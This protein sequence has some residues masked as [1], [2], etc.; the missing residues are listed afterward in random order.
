MTRASR[1]DRGTGY[2]TIG[3]LC[4]AARKPRL[5]AA[6]PSAF[7]RRGGRR[8]SVDLRSNVSVQVGKGTRAGHQLCP[9]LLEASLGALGKI[10]IRG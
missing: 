8:R 9:S 7:R 4:R 10:L 6:G 1:V 2:G 5:G 3:R